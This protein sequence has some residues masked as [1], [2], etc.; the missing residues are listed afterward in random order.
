MPLSNPQK[1]MLGSCFLALLC[2]AN[3]VTIMPTNLTA[4]KSFAFAVCGF[5]LGAFLMYYL[6]QRQFTQ[7][8][9]AL[10]QKNAEHQT[11]LVCQFLPDGTLTFVNEACCNYFGKSR[12]Q[13]IGNKYMIA[14]I[15]KAIAA[16]GKPLPMLGIVYDNESPY[17]QAYRFFNLSSNL[18]VIGNFDGYYTDLNHTWDK[19]LGYTAQELIAQPFMEFV[20]PEDQESRQSAI[21]NFLPGQHLWVL[22]N[23]TERQQAKTA[24]REREQQLAAIA[25]NIPGAVY[26]CLLHANGE[27][28]LLYISEGIKE[29][30]GIDCQEAITQNERLLELIHPEDRTQFYLNKR[31]F[32]QTLQPFSLEYRVI[33]QL[34]KIKW[35]RD[36]SRYFL[37]GTNGDVVV[38]GVLLDI[39][40]VYDELYLRKQ[41]ESALQENQRLLQQIAD[42]TLTMIYIFDLS[43]QRN[44]Y[45][46]RFGQ[47]FF[48]QT[49][50]EIKARG[51]EFFK[52]ILLPEQLSQI[53]A[54]KQKLIST[55]EGEII[56]NELCMKNARGEWRWFHVWEVVFTRTNEGK[57]Q[58]ILGT[59]IDITEQKRSQEI[60]CALETEKEL[61]RLQFRFFSMA[62]HE[63]RTPLSTIL[64][65]TQLLVNSEQE[66]SF[67]KRQ[68]NLKRI[69]TTAKQMTQLLNDILT[70]NRA[71]TGK[72]E[73][74]PNLIEL[75]RFCNHL[76]EEM[77]INAGSQYILKFLTQGKTKKAYLD[78]KILYFILTNLLSNAI[79][80]SPEGGDITLTLFYQENELIFQVQDYGIGI[81]IE[82]QQ[83]PFEPFH[84]GSNIGNIAGTGLGLA[85]VK[86]YLDLQGGKI[87]LDSQVG[88]GTIVIVSIPLIDYQSKGENQIKNHLI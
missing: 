14:L 4:S 11:E 80:Y 6:L 88:K 42:T 45:L 10:L 52:E 27:I 59:A 76:I 30:V 22:H 82:Y 28:S 73:L 72:L 33:T 3:I 53:D 51:V 68:R 2:A 15:S 8:L 75:N 67:E 47:E 58:Q 54:L 32:K 81:P 60:C 56:E 41:A 49:S 86:K 48:G 55:K 66:W 44:V 65:T 87:S 21:A 84:R 57:A 43:E 20:H 50:Q 7:Q 16:Q 71:E 77:Q 35:I 61:R 64:V 85:I 39:S 24:L 70:F 5:S 62:S 26:R 37:S 25:A 29:L 74:E 78:E 12:E 40:D 23:I 69:E 18:L 13:L 31:K 34:G 9:E 46:N 1:I 63:F 79:K 36:S 83:Q 38:D 19:L 17:F